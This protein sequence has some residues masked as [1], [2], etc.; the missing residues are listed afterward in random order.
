[1]RKLMMIGIA[2]IAAI[3]MTAFSAF[4]ADYSTYATEELS[5]MRGTMQNATEEERE[6]FRNEWQKR[7]QTMTREE[8]QE[9]MGN[10]SQKGAGP[11]TGM[12]EK[13]GYGQGTGKGRKW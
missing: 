10:P 5:Q 7:I 2:V 4:S 6:S 12:M 13:K 3:T 9:Y 8:R 1:M 11:G